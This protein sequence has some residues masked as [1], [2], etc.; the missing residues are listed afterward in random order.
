[1][2]RVPFHCSL[3]SV[4]AQAFDLSG[5]PLG[6]GGRDPLEHLQ[7]V[8]K[9]ADLA[10]ELTIFGADRIHPSLRRRLVG[11]VV[12]RIAVPRADPVVGDPADRRDERRQ[13]Q[14]TP[15]I[16]IVTPLS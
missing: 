5:G 15:E 7:P 13:D 8:L 3:M 6:G 1:M 11:L 9:P 2:Y 14:K 16:H 10:L 4:S 12:D